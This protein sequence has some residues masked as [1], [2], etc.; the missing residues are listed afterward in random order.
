MGGCTGDMNYYQQSAT[1]TVAMLISAALGSI[2]KTTPF[3]VAVR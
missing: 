2:T 1:G 3:L